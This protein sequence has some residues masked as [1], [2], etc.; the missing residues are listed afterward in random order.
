MPPTIC[1]SCAIETLTQPKNNLV[2]L[3]NIAKVLEEESFPHRNVKKPQKPNTQN[4]PPTP[5]TICKS[6]AIETLTQPKNNLVKPYNI[7][8]VLEE[9][10]LPHRN[11]KKPQKQNN[12]NQP[13]TPPAICKSCP[14]PTLTQP[15]K[16]LDSTCYIALVYEEGNPNSKCRPP[17]SAAAPPPLPG[18]DRYCPRHAR[19]PV[20]IPP[21]P[22]NHG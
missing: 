18:A 6:C 15:P 12:Q 2:K 14:H 1:K 3:Y 4:Q 20:T 5:P 22:P 11:V 9:E 16:N 21:P 8:K 10:S 17:R 7:A 19:R 13:P